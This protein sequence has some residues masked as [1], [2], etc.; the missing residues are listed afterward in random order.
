V[1]GARSLY[2][3]RETRASWRELHREI[4]PRTVDSIP[5]YLGELFRRICLGASQRH[6]DWMLTVIGGKDLRRRDFTSFS[7]SLSSVSFSQLRIKYSIEL[8]SVSASP[9]TSLLSLPANGFCRSLRV[10]MFYR[11]MCVAG[12]ECR[13]KCRECGDTSSQLTSCFKKFIS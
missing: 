5:E 10:L 6:A 8:V 7:F 4:R 9:S 1:R 13:G 2:T 11:G 12:K 3:G